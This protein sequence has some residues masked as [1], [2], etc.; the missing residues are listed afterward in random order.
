MTPTLLTDRTAETCVRIQVLATLYMTGVIWF[1]Q[2][3]HYPMFAWVG[4][5]QFA[6]WEQRNVVLTTW[7]VGPGMLAEAITTA[8]LF[9]VP[10][11][12]VARRT[13]VIGACLL[14]SIWLS[15]HFLQ[16]PYHDKLAK[17]FDAQSHTLLVNTNWIRTIA[18]SLRAVLVA[19]LFSVGKRSNSQA[20]I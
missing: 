3:V 14:A 5:D 1:V 6:A 2:V 8:G 17:G 16:V 18:W 12:L 19:T 4:D 15:T 11:T 20:L 13:A 10:S 9:F 7:V